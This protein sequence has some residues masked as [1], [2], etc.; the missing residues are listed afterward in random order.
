MPSKAVVGKKGENNMSGSGIGKASVAFLIG[1][2]ICNAIGIA[3]GV[4]PI[5]VLGLCSAVFSIVLGTIGALRDKE[6]KLSRTGL[7]LGILVTI[8]WIAMHLIGWE[9]FFE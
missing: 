3:I 4:M 7:G 6:C 8:A 2:W 5:L 1:A 9:V